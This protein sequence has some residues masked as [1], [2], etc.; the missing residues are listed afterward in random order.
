M[1]TFEK[2]MA[3]GLAATV[4]LTGCAALARECRSISGQVLRLHILANSDSEEDQALKLRVRDR[5]L[6][7]YSAAFSGGESIDQAKKAVA[8]N[9]EAIRQTA[10]EEVLAAGY[11]YQVTAALTNMDFDPRQYGSLTMPAGRYDALRIEIGSGEGQNWWCVMFPP[12]CI[13]AASPDGAEGYF[14]PQEEALLSTDHRLEPR[15]AL[16]EWARGLGA[17]REGTALEESAGE[18]ILRLEQDEGRGS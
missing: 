18:A 9:L 16:V 12:L 6:T 2:A 11:D 5:I 15:F 10:R 17:P 13:P 3:L 1:K 7:D 8:E 14:T 4:F